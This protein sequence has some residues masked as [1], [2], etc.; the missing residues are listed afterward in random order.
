MTS[1]V[2]ISF[3]LLS[4]SYSTKLD[5]IV[6]SKDFQD[7]VN[8]FVEIHNIVYDGAN[9]DLV[10]TSIKMTLEASQKSYGAFLGGFVMNCKSAQNR[11]ANYIA[12]LQ[13]S[14]ED[15]EHEANT[16][17]KQAKTAFDSAKQNQLYLF[18]TRT[19]LQEV[20]KE[21]SN[22]VFEYHRAVAESN[23]KLHVLKQLSDIIEDELLSSPGESFIQLNKFNGKINKI[24]GLIQKAGDSFFS[25]LLHTLVQSAIERKFSD[26][27]VLK[28]IILTL[29]ELTQKIDS[30]KRSKEQTMQSTLELL[31]KQESNLESQVLDYQHLNTKYSS[32]IKE[33]NENLHIMSDDY[34]NMKSEITRKQSELRSLERL[35][36]LEYKMYKSGIRRIIKIKQ[37]LGIAVNHLFNN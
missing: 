13:S 24:K 17:K 28:Q 6:S 2:F 34:R 11:V 20:L 12:S 35:C 22:L 7:I 15:T 23:T 4:I 29:H 10:I 37:D 30:Y 36:D 18:R 27:N 25:P 33:S 31:K 26:Q 8:D 21:I 5:A 16:W 32:M 9:I 1:F 14:A 3:L 19:R